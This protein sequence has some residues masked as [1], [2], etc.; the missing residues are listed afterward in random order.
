MAA[1]Q[2]DL[3]AER[4]HLACSPPLS[5]VH[6]EA[7]PPAWCAPR[8]G[9]RSVPT[10]SA[11]ALSWPGAVRPMDPPDR[12]GRPG[13]R[14][15]PWRWSLP[16]RAIA[17][18]IADS[19]PSTATRSNRRARGAGRARRGRAGA[20]GELFRERNL[21]APAR[22]R[23]LARGQP[24]QARRRVQPAACWAATS[25]AS[26]GPSC[27]PPP[28][29]SR[30]L[31]SPRPRS[32]SAFRQPCWAATR[33]PDAVQAPRHARH[34]GS[35]RGPG[36]RSV[37]DVGGPAVREHSGPCWL[38]GAEVEDPRRPDGARFGSPRFLREP[39]RWPAHGAARLR[40]HGRPGRAG[41]AG[42]DGRSHR[43]EQP[44]A[45]A[46]W[47]RPNRRGVAGA[48]PG[49]IWVSVTGYGRDDPQQRV[50]FGD[51]AVVAGGLG[52]VRGHALRCSAV[53]RSPTG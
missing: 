6:A 36:S 21:P 17:S 37:G 46:A 20:G 7:A 47:R 12:S 15:P 26:R 53:T 43:R 24:G 11:A 10:A 27:A 35:H 51:D 4:A 38:A 49:R 18:A 22:R 19:L 23:R 42:G 31:A 39:A 14:S 40:L 34:P 50:A 32:W 8:P 48:A 5:R 44:S 52:R 29:S 1:C 41:P 9:R 3:R 45:S 28:P 30:R 13:R 16:R 33:G 25:P 2:I